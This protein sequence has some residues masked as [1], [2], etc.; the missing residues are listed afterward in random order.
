MGIQSIDP[1]QGKG[2][3][4]WPYFFDPQIYS[5]QRRCCYFTFVGLVKKIKHKYWSIIG[6]KF[7]VKSLS[8]PSNSKICIGKCDLGQA[9]VELVGLRPT[10]SP[11]SAIYTT[12]VH[13]T[14]LM[15]VER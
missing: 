3:T 11:S 10:A 7:S 12:S 8:E 1:I 14:H 2:P 5:R 4:D 13:H 6:I 15:Q 9:P